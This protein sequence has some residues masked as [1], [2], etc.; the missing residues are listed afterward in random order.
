M[1]RLFAFLALLLQLGCAGV[2]R[3]Q[4]ALPATGAS[5]PAGV[6]Y[7]IRWVLESA[8]YRALVRQSFRVAG[9]RL[10][11]LADGRE[12]GSWAISVDA[13]ETLISNV[14]YSLELYESGV[15]Y[16]DERW[17]DW[18]LRKEAPALPGAR[19]FLL[20]V[21]ELGGRIAVVTNRPE[22]DCPETRENLRLVDLPFDM[23]LCRRGESRDKEDRWEAVRRGE[24]DPAY[25]PLE[26]L[27]WVGDN[28]GDFPSLDQSLRDAGAGA[29]EDF[30][31][32][33]V[34]MPN[35]MYGS[36]E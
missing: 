36:W 10:A 8:E 13:D 30:G 1:P 15:P 9:E 21:R 35:P 31:G 34:V 17:R 14:G 20:R 27:M 6:P 25:G 16:S 29:F 5:P 33:F 19:D 23:V 3:P 11:E 26:I 32:R 7:A 2:D 24:A 18:V 12:P 22:R 4:V 28:V